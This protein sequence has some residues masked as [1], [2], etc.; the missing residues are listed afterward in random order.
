[1]PFFNIYPCNSLK[2][3]AEITSF[4]G[5]FSKLTFK[6]RRK[7]WNAP[8][9][10]NR[11][12]L[13]E[14]WSVVVRCLT[15]KTQINRQMFVPCGSL[16]TEHSTSKHFSTF[17]PEYYRDMKHFTPISLPPIWFS[18]HHSEPQPCHTQSAPLC[19]EMFRTTRRHH[20]LSI[21]Q[22]I[23]VFLFYYLFPDKHGFHECLFHKNR[24]FFI[25]T[26]YILVLRNMWTRF[27]HLIP[28]FFAKK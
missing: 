10:S 19:L 1:M 17:K 27:H 28:L 25:N 2:R 11:C 20:P 26:P 12:F 22:K 4:H 23:I 5:L 14:Q 21:L 6:T 8:I 24:V 7:R 3:Q 18:Y 16:F 15:P 13:S 9:E